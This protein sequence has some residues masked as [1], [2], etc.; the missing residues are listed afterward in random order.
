MEFW[1]LQEKCGIAPGKAR[2]W[3]PPRSRKQAGAGGG[4][5]SGWL[6]L[7]KCVSGRYGEAAS[8][9]RWTIK[10]RSEAVRAWMCR[11]W[12][13]GGGQGSEVQAVCGVCGSV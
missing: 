1:V 7:L 4:V 8:D 10:G 9:K 5:S 12:S 2:R 11:W 6:S 3:Q 13:S